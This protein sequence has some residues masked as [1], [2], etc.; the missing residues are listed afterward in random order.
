[1]T[2]R[3]EGLPAVRDVWLRDQLAGW[4]TDTDAYFTA[5]EAAKARGGS[6]TLEQQTA[7]FC[8]EYLQK[9]ALLCTARQLVTEVLSR[10]G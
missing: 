6:E 9:T 7:R 1:V 4:L 2:A 3:H 5:C 8:A 10:R